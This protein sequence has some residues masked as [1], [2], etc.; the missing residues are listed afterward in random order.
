MGAAWG[1]A[2][3]RTSTLV[4]KTRL[5]NFPTKI[6]V[7][8]RKI[9]TL[10]A[11]SGVHTKKRVEGI[12]GEVES[13]TIRKD[14]SKYANRSPGRLKSALKGAGLPP[15][16]YQNGFYLVLLPRAY[17]PG[18]LPN[19]ARPP[20]RRPLRRYSPN[21]SSPGASSSLLALQDGTCG[22]LAAG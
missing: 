21:W 9:S 14:G 3:A 15:V 6:G 5:P 16:P 13:N 12:Q 8:R 7:S 11:R 1:G 10:A 18:E 4:V 17:G 2:P 22:F 19:R 20:R